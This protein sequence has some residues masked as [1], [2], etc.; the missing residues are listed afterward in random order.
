MEKQPHQLGC[1]F[2]VLDGVSVLHGLSS[3][4]RLSEDDRREKIRRI[5]E[6]DKLIMEAGFISM[7]VFISPFYADR[8]AVRKLMSDG[9][10]FEIYW[11]AS[12]DT[13]EARDAKGLYKKAR[14]GEIKKLYWRRLA[15]RSA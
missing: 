4:L 10:F 14:A 8:E 2:F 5:G 1:C 13:C 11:K 15:L 12:L 7:T 6:A 3:N 9:N